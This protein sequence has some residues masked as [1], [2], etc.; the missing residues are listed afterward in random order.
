[1]FKFFTTSG[2]QILAYG[3]LI[4]LQLSLN[5]LVLTLKG[6]TMGLLL[7]TLT[8]YGLALHSWLLIEIQPS[9]IQQWNQ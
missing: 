7:L 8:I 5:L 2:T 4:L 6:W 9:E 3:S 1:M